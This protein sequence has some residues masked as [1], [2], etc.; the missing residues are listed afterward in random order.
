MHLGRALAAAVLGLTMVIAS[1][2]GAVAAGGSAPVT[3]GDRLEGRAGSLLEIAPLRN[4]SD[5]DGDPLELCRLGTV[6]P[7]L[8]A[9]LFDDDTIMVVAARAGTYTLDYYACDFDHLT[10]GTITVVATPAAVISLRIRKLRQPGKLRVVNRSA[11]RVSFAWG[12]AEED[13]AD[14][15]RWIRPGGRVVISVRRP[16]IMWSA[17]NLHQDVFKL[18]AVRGIRL[19]KGTK[20]LAPGAPKPGQLDQSFGRFATDGWK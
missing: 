11:F 3:V 2:S 20:A 6:P 14:G 15:S 4:D 12:S 9:E 16:S 7:G 1:S 10:R 18:G 17:A 8:E 5:A 19:P 13:R